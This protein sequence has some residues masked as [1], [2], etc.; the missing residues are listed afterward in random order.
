V[1]PGEEYN[2]LGYHRAKGATLTFEV[3]GVERRVPVKAAISWRGQW[4]LVHLTQ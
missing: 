3:D 1:K 4:Y 2:K